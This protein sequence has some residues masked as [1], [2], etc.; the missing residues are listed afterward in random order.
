MKRIAKKTM[1]ALFI[2]VMTVV[3]MALPVTALDMPF[4]DHLGHRWE[5]GV[6]FVY[7]RDIVQG[8]SDGTFKPDKILNRAEL[9]KVIVASSFDE[10]S[11]DYYDDESCFNDVAANQWYT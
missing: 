3:A 4:S 10:W 2:S 9:L 5:S 1:V 8:Y 6:E 11:Y 7:N